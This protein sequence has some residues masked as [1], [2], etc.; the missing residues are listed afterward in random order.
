MASLVRGCRSCKA[1]AIFYRYCSHGGLLEKGQRETEEGSCQKK[2]KKKKKD[3]EKEKEQAGGR[4]AI[5]VD[6]NI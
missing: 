2:K 6:A 5:Y 3:R 4:E 1:G